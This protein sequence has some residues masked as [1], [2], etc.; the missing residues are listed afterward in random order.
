MN[1]EL[2]IKETPFLFRII[3]IIEITQ[4]SLRYFARS[5]EPRNKRHRFFI[6]ILFKYNVMYHFM[7][8]ILS[9]N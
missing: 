2:Y 4:H 6:F 9:N 5:R 3:F 8:Q 1:K 7:F